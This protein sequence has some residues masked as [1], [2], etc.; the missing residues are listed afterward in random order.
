MSLCS[1]KPEVRK[2]AGAKCVAFLERCPGAELNTCLE[3]GRDV[4]STM[5]QMG[6]NRGARPDLPATDDV[7]RALD[8]VVGESASEFV[9]TKRERPERDPGQDLEAPSTSAR[10]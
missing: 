10:A 2:Q 3:H 8:E 4:L 7:D 5:L 6:V 1:D 9:V